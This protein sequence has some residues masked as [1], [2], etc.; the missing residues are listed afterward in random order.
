MK[1]KLLTTLCLFSSVTAFAAD[2]LVTNP[3]FESSL[4]NWTKSGS[5][6]AVKTA[7]SGLYAARAGTAVGTLTQDVM[8]KLTI[9]GRYTLSFYG[10][11][12]SMG[13]SSMVS[14][15]FKNSRGGILQE[16]RMVIG[17]TAWKQYSTTFTVPANSTVAEIYAI[18]EAGASSYMYV[19]AFSLIS[20]DTATRPVNT[21]P[22]VLSTQ[23]ISTNEDTPVTFS[24]NAGTDAEGNALTYVKVSD[25]TS[26]SLS[27][28]GGA[29]RVCTYT[30]AANFNGQVTFTYKVNDGAL[31]SNIATGTIT[32]NPVNDLPVLPAAQSVSTAS[33]TAVSFKLNDAVDIDSTNITYSIVSKPASGTVTC[34]G[35]NCTYTPASGFSGTTSFTYKANDGV[36]DSNVATV[37]VTVTAAANRAPVLPSSQ[38]VSTAYNTAVNFSLNAGTDDDGNALTYSIVSQPANGTLSCSALS[39]AF[40]PASGFSGTTSF[41]YKANDGKADSNVATV[42]ITVASAPVVV[43]DP[44]PVPAPSTGYI[45]LGVGGG[46]AMSGVS[47]SPYSNLWFVGTDMGTLFKSTD[48]GKSWNAVNHFQAVFDSDLTKAVSVGFSADGVT[49]FHASAG[50]NPKRSTDAGETFTAINMGLASGEIIKYFYSDSSNANIMYAGTT[51]GL[52]R[53][54]NKGTSWTRVN[55]EEAVGTFIDH[56]TN[57]KVYHATKTKVL[58]SGDDG[59][60][61]STYYTP[62]AGSV[63]LFAGGSDASGVTL[64]MSDSDGSNA[65][66]WAGK[67]LNDWGQTSIDQTYAACGF[68]WV[69]KNGGA[70]TKNAQPVGDHLKMAENDSATIYTTGGRAWIRQYGTKVHV[71]RDKGQTW[72]LKLNQIDYDVVPYAPWS[73]DKIEYSAVALDV[74]W[75]DSGYESFAINQRNSAVVA[76]SGYFFLHSSLNT[77]DN[78]LAAFTKY[79]DTGTPTAGKKWITRGLEVISVYKMKFHPTNSNLLYGASAD[80]GGVVSEDHGASFRIPSHQYNSFYDYAFDPADDLVVYSAA[81]SLHDFPNEWHANAVTG[82]GGIYKSVDRGRSWKRLTP[83]DTNYNR[84]FL[85]VGYD[86][87]NDV[88]YGGTHETG[89]AVSYNDG[90][91]WAYLNT[92]L[93]AGNKIIPQIEVDPNTG[94]VYALLTGDAPTFSNQ[95]Y[96]GVYFLD[97]ANGSKTWKLLRGTVN[98][99]KDADAGYKLWYYPTAFAIDFNNPSTIWM[100]DYENKGNW[101]MT[102][103]W[104]T[105]DGGNTWNRMKQV[106]HATDIKID[107][108]NP[109]QVHVSGYYDLTGG[110]GNGGMLYTKDGGATWSKNSLPPLQRNAR[111]VTLDPKDSSKIYYSYF[112]GG[113]LYGANPA[114]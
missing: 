54:T 14:I 28:E 101:L 25:P 108:K 41:T 33:N 13:V 87:K 18:K 114:K 83:V 3:G 32:V 51:K 74:G 60:T 34:A 21:A 77:G 105:T 78:W 26:G 67:Y 82:N 38:A 111:S 45:P 66:S 76:G 84:Q 59:V 50:I 63:R 5:F 68:V 96:T 91:S 30:P 89:I 22:A 112:G 72:G 23:S 4:N 44:D 107:P 97:V 95:P 85:S 31:D 109:N 92:G 46:G 35:Q 65:C 90:A 10:K 70:F 86:A 12:D 81:G 88:I 17:S 57:G 64:A 94:N 15:R 104:K 11:L 1:K 69:S 55:S 99:P 106:T 73:K 39:C 71:S 113:I 40:T 56:N 110:W 49:V 75:W 27:C 20:L 102:G 62:I 53:T 8:S 103:A 24:L 9:G 29:S 98:Y 36:G 42:T 6:S 7:Q 61:F 93:P 100:V 58:V 2:N 43:P 79:A 19:D 16:N 37:T 80:I 52:L 47:I 48:L